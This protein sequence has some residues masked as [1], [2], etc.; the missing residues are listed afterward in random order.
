MN[1][2]LA[3]VASHT[4]TGEVLLSM[5]KHIC[6]FNASCTKYITYLFFSAS[7]PQ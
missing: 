7:F 2:A 1:K 4:S 5:L 3:F 6:W